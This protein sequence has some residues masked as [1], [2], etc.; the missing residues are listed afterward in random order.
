MFAG[1]LSVRYTELHTELGPSQEYLMERGAA[2]RIA[3]KFRSR[4]YRLWKY[5][6]D[7]SQFRG[8]GGISLLF[9]FL[10]ALSF[11][12]SQVF[13]NLKRPPPFFNLVQLFLLAF[14]LL[15]LLLFPFT[16]SSPRICIEF[17]PWNR[18]IETNFYKE[19]LYNWRRER[20]KGWTIWRSRIHQHFYR[21]QERGYSPKRGKK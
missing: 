14:P 11:H 4:V 21:S 3:N 7:S 16:V 8:S 5:T 15:L 13:F 20:G 1:G 17:T 2:W 19:E 6:F 9:S 18:R 12:L 10:P